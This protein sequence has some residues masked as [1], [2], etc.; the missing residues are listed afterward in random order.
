MPSFDFGAARL[1]SEP[2]PD[3]IRG[4]TEAR[5]EALLIARRQRPA[6]V[7]ALPSRSWCPSP[8]RVRVRQPCRCHTRSSPRRCRRCRPLSCP[9]AQA[10]V[11]AALRRP[12]G[13]FPHTPPGRSTVTVRVGINGFGRIGRN[14]FR[15]VEQSARDIEFVAANDLGRSTRMAHL[16]KYDSVLGRCP[17]DV[18]VTDD[19]ISVDGKHDQGPRRARPGQAA[20][21]RP[22]RRRRDRVD[23]LLHRRRPRP[24]APRR[25][26]PRR[27]SSPRRPRA[28]TSRSCMGVN[29]DEYDPAAAHGHLQR[30]LHHQLPRPR[31]PRSS[32][33]RSASSAA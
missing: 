9:Q 1:R 26:A 20:L 16:L 15:A 8:S 11:R 14:F 27:S 6:S 19:G 12:V 32:T 5:I 4:R 24:A 31:W 22:R 3:S 29:D 28:P 10:P 7:R 25:A 18:T 21:G 23:R 13:S 30:V 33:T 2:A 17:D